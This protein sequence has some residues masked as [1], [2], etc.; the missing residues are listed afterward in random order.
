MIRLRPVSSVTAAQR[1]SRPP[2][3]KAEIPL[4]EVAK[5]ATRDDGWIVVDGVV[6]DITNFVRNHPGWSFGGSTSTALAI[7]R[8]LG[9]DCTDEFAETHDKHQTKMLRE[10]AIG[11]LCDEPD[12]AATVGDAAEYAIGTLCDEPDD[13]ATVGDAR[14]R[15]RR[16]RAR[17]RGHL[18]DALQPR[19]GVAI[20]GGVLAANPR[21]M[22]LGR[23]VDVPVALSPYFMFRVRVRAMRSLTLEIGVA[24]DAGG[25]TKEWFVDGAGRAVVKI[26]GDHS[27]RSDVA[28]AYGHRFGAGERVGLRLGGG[29]LR[30]FLGSKDLGVAFSGVPRHA[31]PFVRFPTG[32]N[33]GERRR[34][35]DLGR[36]RGDRPRRRR[37]RRDAGAIDGHLVVQLMGPELDDWLSFKAFAPGNRLS[38]RTATPRAAPPA[39]GAGRHAYGAARDADLDR[40]LADFR[41]AFLDT[42]VQSRPIYASVDVDIS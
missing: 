26:R 28:F 38:P 15:T 33:S 14:S 3:T 19:A 9:S 22:S 32:G 4:S 29:D 36:P 34:G 12:D 17:R 11:T 39:T 18:A 7:E 31:K 5:H 42:G 24:A 10:Y 20:A 41:V 37:R 23:V 40:P 35:R 2:T 8:V 6:Y 30:F 27:V 1:P 21:W 13:A 16:S 25:R